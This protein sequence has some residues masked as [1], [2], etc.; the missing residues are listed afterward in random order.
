MIAVRRPDFGNVVP[1]RRGFA[2]PMWRS[3][4]TAASLRAILP[5]AIGPRS[6]YR[7]SREASKLL[8]LLVG[9]TGFEPATPTSRTDHVKKYHGNKWL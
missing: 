6:E 1:V 4:F 8:F 7:G 5:T 9:V 3:V 2:P